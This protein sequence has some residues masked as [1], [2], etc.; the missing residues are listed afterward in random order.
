MSDKKIKVAGYSQRI[1]FGNGIEYRPFSPDLVGLQLATENI[2]P[3]FTMGNFNITTNMD[4]KVDKSFV[5]KDFSDFITLTD[6]DLTVEKNELVI[7]NT[8]S[9]N[10]NIDNSK[11]K[12][13]ALFG[14]LNEF[15]RVS[16]ENII[17]TWPASL[18]VQ[19]IYL[20][21]IGETI[22]KPTFENVIYDSLRNETSFR[23]DVNLLQNKFNINF[24]ENGSI[25]NTFSETNDLRN[26]TINYFSYVIS[27]N[28]VEYEVLNFTGSTSLTNDFIYFNVKGQ[29][30]NSVLPTIEYH[31]KPNKTNEEI[32]FNKLNKFESYL[33]N[34]F[35]LPKYKAIFNFPIKSDSGIVL[36]TSEAVIWPVSDGYNIDFDSGEYI[37]YVSDLLKITDNH[38]LY[39]SNL[40]NRFLVSES[41]TSF[42]TVP[43]VLTDETL[44]NS[45]Q[46]VNK[47]LNIY[48]RSFD[49]INNYINGVSFANV[50]SYDKKDN[51]PD[52]FVKNLA[53]ILGWDVTTALNNPNLLA[54]NLTPSNST[55][56]GS[57]I[58]LTAAQADIELWRRLILNSPW[59]WK[60]KGARKSVEFLLRFIGTPSG[61]VELNEYVYQANAPIDIELFKQALELNG[62]PVILDEYPIDDD[63]FPNFTGNT[64]DMFFQNNGL[65]YRETGGANA[66]I[67]ISTGNN[68]HVGPYDGGSKFLNQFTTLIPDFSAVTIHNETSATT[69]VNLFTNYNVG[70]IT[71]YS[72]ATYVDVVNNDNTNLADC[73]VVTTNIIHDYKPTEQKTDCGCISPSSDDI[74]SVCVKKIVK[75]EPQPCSELSTP[76]SKDVQNGNYV[77]NH[78]QYNSDG[79]IFKIDGQPITKRTIFTSRE[80]CKATKGISFYTDNINSGTNEVTSGYACCH[81]NKC[82]CSLACN[83]I[84]NQN[85][86]KFPSSGPNIGEYVEF[87]TLFG[88]GVKKVTLPDDS[89]CPK[90]WTVAVPNITDPY[91]GDV[92]IGC[93]ITPTG[94]SEIAKLIDYYKK[95]A[96]GGFGTYTCCLFTRDIYLKNFPSV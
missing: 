95:K 89:N 25:A 3:L 7:E 38:D 50:V 71:D 56:S 94:L 63:G 20:N 9:V 29:I 27:V 33:L 85:T 47:L 65:W 80:C 30:F 66:I 76:P 60:S 62:L 53:K 58:G 59:I 31:I 16:L 43:L 75:P 54:N 36:Y 70:E 73:V 21:S 84:M 10:L 74:L 88:A 35:T 32:F 44:D 79:S 49:D 26:L 83:W 93:K 8:N 96:D 57:S 4:P 64:D 90:T 77:F 72:G 22:V 51:T 69:N 40:M 19:P 86:Y 45:G 82:G 42:D 52:N 12:N 55:Y 39:E 68:P 17:I 41:I 2:A 1:Q 78:Y 37:S 87:T 67:D 15:V 6:L 5:T 61:L 34:R 91:T 81:S 14:S 24:L 13:Y 18:F 11:L 28:N 23:V 92:G 48:G 46:K